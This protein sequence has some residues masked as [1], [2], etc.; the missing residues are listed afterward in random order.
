MKDKQITELEIQQ[1]IRKFLG[2]GG[3]IKHLPDEITP[4]SIL[5]GA[6]FAMFET[7][8]DSFQGEAN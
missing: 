4:P 1:A 5:V 7:I 6:K 2:E 8:S 3:L